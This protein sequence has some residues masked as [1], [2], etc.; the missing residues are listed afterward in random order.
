MQRCAEKL[1]KKTATKNQKKFYAALKVAAG[2]EG[3]VEKI[4]PYGKRANEF[5]GK[6]TVP[7]FITI[8]KNIYF[9]VNDFYTEGYKIFEKVFSF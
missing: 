9:Y 3:S 4:V 8:E 1:I 2:L 6:N 7:D 5:F